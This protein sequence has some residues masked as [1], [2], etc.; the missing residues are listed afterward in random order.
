MIYVFYTHGLDMEVKKNWDAHLYHIVMDIVVYMCLIKY[1]V[2]Q[3][4]FG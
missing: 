2:L 3:G 4:Y 1:L